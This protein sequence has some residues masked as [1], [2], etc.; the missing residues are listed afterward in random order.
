MKSP[1]V[2]RSNTAVREVLCKPNKPWIAERTLQLTKK[3]REMK[4][5]RQEL[6]KREKEYRKL[7]NVLRKAAR[8][9][10]EEWLRGQC[11]EIEM[12]ARNNRGR[13]KLM[14][15]MNRSWNL[16]QSAIKDK[17]L[18]GRGEVR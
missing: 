12:L 4:Q 9:D 14:K 5:G 16:K 18:Q 17:M 1:T 7:C 15:Q 2:E 11:Q 6:A 8:T 3:K 13:D 10:K